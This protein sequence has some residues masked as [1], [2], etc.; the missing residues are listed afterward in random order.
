MRN[1]FATALAIVLA[2][3]AVLPILLEAAEPA[4]I[5]KL[6][7]EKLE[8]GKLWYQ[9]TKAAF[10]AETV[11]I[12][13]MYASSIGWKQAAYE[14]ATTRPQRI[15]AIEAHRDRMKALHD[16]IN[17]LY[18]EGAPRWRSRKRGRRTLLVHR[19]GNLAD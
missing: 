1:L 10:E 18:Q 13:Q 14:I 17:A 16:Q 8:A 4:T 11:T 7:R 2:G 15:A 6:R 19:G 5:A 3:P 9:A 12:D